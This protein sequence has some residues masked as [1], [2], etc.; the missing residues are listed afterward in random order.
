MPQENG[1][2]TADECKVIISKRLQGIT[3]VSLL[4]SVFNTIGLIQAY[5]AYFDEL[6]GKWFTAI[7]KAITEIKK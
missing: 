1:Q 7:N 2:P 6:N 5:P 3:D 4:I